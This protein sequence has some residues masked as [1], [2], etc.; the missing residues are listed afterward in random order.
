MQVTIEIN[1]NNTLEML[2]IKAA[3]EKLAKN[4]SKENILFLAELSDKKDVNKKLESKK[5]LIKS[6]L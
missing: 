2:T 5:L 6:F 4:M 3:M 1:A